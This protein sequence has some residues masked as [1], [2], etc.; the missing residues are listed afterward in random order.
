MTRRQPAAN[1]DNRHDEGALRSS[2]AGA[3]AE[4]FGGRLR[5]LRRRAQL[6]QEELAERSGV[7]VRTVRN[8]ESGRVSA[9]RQDTARLL[10]G[11]LRLGG[12]VRQAFLGAARRL[13]SA[14]S[15]G[16]EASIDHLPDPVRA[17][18][19][20]RLPAD[21]A[22]VIVL[23][24]GTAVVGKTA[25]AVGPVCTVTR[26]LLEPMARRRGGHAECVP[27]GCLAG[28]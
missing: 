27:S 8:V 6:S 11:G 25:L 18:G 15:G 1:E 22:M 28:S 4:S 24:S 21:T 12:Y 20:V 14:G 16:D 2:A 5:E 9:P 17:T 13:G 7:S 26:D 3:T 10:A 19:V 23:I